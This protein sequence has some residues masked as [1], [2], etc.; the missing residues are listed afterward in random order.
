MGL[1]NAFVCGLIWCA[2]IG[3]AMSETGI[4]VS[5]DM[6]ILTLAIVV[7]GALAGGD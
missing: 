1:L 4:T 5:N 7:A 2:V 6:Q 3:L